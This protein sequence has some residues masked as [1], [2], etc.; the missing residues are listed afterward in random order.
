MKDGYLILPS[1]SNVNTIRYTKLHNNNTDMK[2][3]L[4]KMES[5]MFLHRLQQALD[6]FL[7]D[8]IVKVSPIVGQHRP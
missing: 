3:N 2:D 6:A 8:A 1:K 4:S 7:G 5:D